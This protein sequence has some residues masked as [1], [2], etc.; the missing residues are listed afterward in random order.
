MKIYP[1][2]LGL[3]YVGLP[4]FVRLAKSYCSTG[5]DIN[6]SRINELKSGL[7]LNNE[8]NK[9]ELNLKNYSKL[10]SNVK[11]IKN[12]NFFI[13]TV[14]TP[15]YKNK[16]PDLRP[17]VSAT[18]IVSKYIK[19]NDIVFYESTVYPGVTEEVCA[20]IIEKKTKLKSQ[21]DFFLGYSPERI[22]PGDN[23]HKV[24]K[25]NKIVSFPN[26][27]LKIRKKIINV[28][29][30]ISKKIILSNSIKESETSKVIENIQR[31]INIAF[32]N[33][34]FMICKKININFFNIMKLASTKWNFLKF[35][36]G[37]VGGHCLP[38]D[39]YY[40]YALAKKNKI[41]AKFMLAGRNVNNE[42]ENFVHKSILKKINESNYKNILVAG[43]SYKA[44]VS[45][46][47]NS[48]ALNIYN[49]LKKNK[50]F[51][52]FCYDPV[53]NSKYIKKYKIYNNLRKNFF[54]DLIVPLV[55]HSKLLNDLKVYKNSKTT[56]FDIF[57]FFN[58]D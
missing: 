30:K 23:E 38:V 12:C 13:I 57:G 50:K 49:K 17:L 42:M 6:K 24:E 39:P 10:T 58:N 36:P 26:V 20:K 53:I 15:I 48:L 25:I 7:D 35:S 46:I 47:R 19:K 54:F 33:E 9:S 29:K 3:G 44:N 16:K 55:P 43:A 1:C 40:L 22:N 31:D 41:N 51:N 2:I 34:I 21:K 45:D 5:F 56:I 4:L 32:V 8:F 11:D 28:Y 37:L 27:P 52:T 18:R 14:P